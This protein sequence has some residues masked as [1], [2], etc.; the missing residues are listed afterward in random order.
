MLKD[1]LVPALTIIS[2]LIATWLSFIYNSNRLKTE[3]IERL[4][5][6]LTKRPSIPYI[7]EAC[8]VRIHRCRPI[9]YDILKRLLRLSNAFEVIQLISPGRRYLNIFQFS[10]KEGVIQVSYKT[11]FL[12]P[13]SR[14]ITAIIALFIVTLSYSMAVKSLMDISLF[15]DGSNWS[16]QKCLDTFISV[17]M[18]FTSMVLSIV[19]TIQIYVISSAPSRLSKVNELLRE[20]IMTRPRKRM[21]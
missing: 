2:G 6:E 20:N 4:S 21:E 19:C 5:R 7:V 1:F 16:G 11:P 14:A 18:L 9:P 8:V 12:K 17:Y 10:V 15:L 3:E 13:W